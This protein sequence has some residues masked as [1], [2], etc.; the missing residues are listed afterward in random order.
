[1]RRILSILLVLLLTL[2]IAGASFVAW[3]GAHPERVSTSVDRWLRAWVAANPLEESVAL[4]W[5]GL[6]W[7]PWTGVSLA[8]VALGKGADSVVLYGLQTKGL[9]YSGGVLHLASCTW[10]SLVVTGQPSGD[11]AHW[12]DPW[13]PTDTTGDPFWWHIDS[14]QGRIRYQASINAPSYALNL[15]LSQ[16][17]NQGAHGLDA[18]LSLPLDGLEAMALHGAYAP[19]TE[20]WTLTAETAAWLAESQLI[21]METGPLLQWDVSGKTWEGSA[22]GAIQGDTS[23]AAW[24]LL[25]TQAYWRDRTWT[26]EGTLEGETWSLDIQEY[27]EERRLAHINGTGTF[28]KASVDFL[29]NNWQGAVLDAQ[30]AELILDGRLRADIAFAPK[31]HAEWQG[32]GDLARWG[33]QTLEGWSLEG[34]GD[35][36]ELNVVIG[37]QQP[38]IQRLEG[39]FLLQQEKVLLSWNWNENTTWLEGLGLP[40]QGEVSGYFS[41][42]NGG[43][44]HLENALDAGYSPLFLDWHASQ[45]GNHS[46]E[47][48]VGD[49]RASLKSSQGPLTW[50]VE[51]LP[52]DVPGALNAWLE[53]RFQ[54]GAQQGIQDVSVAGPG[55]EANYARK[56]GYQQLKASGNL[57]GGPWTFESSSP[58]QGF[59]PTET[60]LSLKT[61]ALDAGLHWFSRKDQKDRL[62]IAF[63][64]RDV[65]VAS[66]M[67]LALERG[68]TVWKGELLPSTLKIQGRKGEFS[69]GKRLVY[70][71]DR[72]RFAFNDALVW[73]GEAG[74][75]GLV[76]ALSPDPNEVLRVQWEAL[77]LAVWT[78]A[79]GLPELPIEGELWG[80]F[81]FAG[82]IGQ[83]Q[84]SADAWIPELLVDKRS[85]GTMESQWDV[86]METGKVAM[87]A[88]AGWPGQDSLWFT[89][90]GERNPTWDMEFT[91]DRLPLNLLNGFTEGS[92]EDWA[93]QLTAELGLREINGDFVGSGSGR[94]E[95]A[96]FTLPITGVRY[97][98]SPR[99]SLR[100]K[101]LTLQGPLRDQKGIGALAVNGKVDFKAPPGKTVDFLFTSGRF[102]AVDLE[103]GENFYGHVR[104][105]GEGRLSG[106]FSGLRLDLEASPLDSSLFVLPL[107]APVTLDDVG[108]MSFKKREAT[109]LGLATT[110]VKSDFRFEMGLKVHVTPAITARIILDETV[111]DILEGQGQGEL[112]IDY[113]NSGD[114]QMNGM[115]TL[116]KGTY[117]FTLENLINKPFS[118]EPGANLTWSGDPY[119]AQV[120]LTA[121]YKTRTN[122]GPYLG[123]SSQ[124]RLP[125]DVK[126][127]VTDDL[128][129]PN[130]GFDIALPTAGSATQAALQ[131][132]LVSSD[133]KTTQVLSLLT[134][135]SFWDQQQ[136]WSS[137][138]V[139]AVETNTTQVLAQQFSNFMSQGLG[140]NWDVQ[141]AYSNDAQTLQRQ[142]DA[143]IGRSFMDDRLKIQTELGIPVGA[144][145]TSLGLGD[146][147]LTYRLSEDGRWLAQAYSV[148][149]AD[150][151]FTGQPVAQKQGLGVQLQLSGSSWSQLWQRLRSK[152]QP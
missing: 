143:S 30:F 91:I 150:M 45:A 72:Q 43:S 32:A 97:E 47:A 3:L 96:A 144:R 115:L 6:E 76:G 86:D 89:A 29:W 42:A 108:F 131:S 145:Q 70:D 107:D 85:L 120:D 77:P 138:G 135:H 102:L 119:H 81:I 121:V 141:L 44:A 19:A 67:N 52:S 79:F 12:V 137:T 149:N 38:H 125:V 22:S 95:N 50:N 56:K 134:L 71:W 41:W 26:A 118:V 75:I 49:F 1:M 28:E 98:G 110:E 20:T 11:W 64:A 130:L 37:L 65:G 24:Q 9:G 31:L 104:A 27:Q 54:W 69:G 124:E 99:L 147:T 13:L 127:H 116:N 88:L 111:G 101:T 39:N 82:A 113:P 2:L 10:D 139:S 136:G 55:F 146:V 112:S 4:H 84:T 61:E 87:K 90:T 7:E 151:A 21:L 128:M 59:R 92:L 14:V 80:Q 83:W 15:A 18:V 126:L 63:K 106:G 132:R 100:G 51:E 93:G 46:L 122:P 8:R 48:R 5:E 140:S 123:L 152:S 34:T 109:A 40:V 33:D 66:D 60:H 142:M 129:Q 58:L 73:S 16:V 103:R 148:R 78:Q 53:G 17:S 62:Q 94:L 105:K 68:A 35:L 117:L 74:A 25:A 36:A 114:L 23:Y 133:E 57:A